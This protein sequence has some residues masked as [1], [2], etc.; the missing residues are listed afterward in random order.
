LADLIKNANT[1]FGEPS[2]NV[3][4]TTPPFTFNSFSSPLFTQSTRAQTTD[5]TTP[6]LFTSTGFSFASSPSDPPVE[7]HLP[8]LAQTTPTCSFGLRPEFARSAKVETVDSPTGL[9]S[10]PTG[11]SFA[12]PPDPHAEVHS[13]DVAQTTPTYDFGLRPELARSNKSQTSHFSTPTGFSFAQPHSD[14]RA[15]V[16]S[17]GVA[18]TLPTYDFGLRPHPQSVKAHTNHFSTPTG[19]SFAPS[20]SGPPMEGHSPDVAQTTPTYDF[21]LRP[22]F[23]QPSK[24][25]NS[26]FSTPNRFSFAPSPSDHS[27][28]QGTSHQQAPRT[29]TSVADSDRRRGDND[30]Q[31]SSS[32]TP[33]KRD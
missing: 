33:G 7:G 4:E 29:G 2:P 10:T 14:L 28:V 8:D 25:H 30:H 32:H 20:S 1:L 26:H 24:A 3:A 9:F 31:R 19:L 12:Q 13:P 27:R 17:P 16:R 6:N 18:Q 22:E 15:E 21:G 23:T 11:F 5:Y